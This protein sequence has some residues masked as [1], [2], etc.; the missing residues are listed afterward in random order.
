MRD[1]LLQ[2]PQ[3]AT[4]YDTL[5]DELIARTSA[6]EQRRLHHL[7][8]AKELRDRKPTQLLRRMRQ[9]L[10]DNSSE[11]SLFKQLFLQRLPRNT[12]LIL[13]PTSSKSTLEELASVADKILEVTPSPG[14]VAATSSGVRPKCLS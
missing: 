12:Q 9:L 14:Q 10:G 3:G 11:D 13:A 4:P 1:L 5:K 2:S 8:I 7:L 6:S